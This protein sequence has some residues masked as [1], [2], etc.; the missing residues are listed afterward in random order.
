[1]RKEGDAHTLS[2][3]WRVKA[4]IYINAETFYRYHGQD[5][6]A[7]AMR[8]L[9]DRCYQKVARLEE[10]ERAESRREVEKGE[11]EI[12]AFYQ[13]EF[14]KL[15]YYLDEGG[16]KDQFLGLDGS[17]AR[18]AATERLSEAEKK[19]L[20]RQI[21]AKH[22]SIEQKVASGNATAEEYLLAG[23]FAPG[24][25]GTHGE[26]LIDKGIS[27]LEKRNPKGRDALLLVSRYRDQAWRHETNK[28]YDAALAVLTKARTVVDAH[29]D[30]ARKSMSLEEFWRM[31]G[32]MT[33]KEETPGRTDRLINLVQNLNREQVEAWHWI[34]FALT[35]S[36]LKAQ[37]YEQL[38]LPLQARREYQHLCV[39]LKEE[40]ACNDMERLK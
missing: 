21:Q 40:T 22:R 23:Y 16:W 3:Y 26:E 11:A 5:E 28:R 24:D 18:R 38:D 4:N 7:A 30:R 36:H 32:V 6:K 35:I 34:Q 19:K 12:A 13:T 8:K 15:S 39:E 33:R 9:S 1:L 10:K 37:I 20:E 27:L 31:F 25:D 14:G 29:L 2:G 17:A